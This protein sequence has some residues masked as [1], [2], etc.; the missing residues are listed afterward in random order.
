[1]A[2]TLYLR[3]KIRPMIVWA[4]I[5]PK[6]SYKEKMREEGRLAIY[7]FVCCGSHAQ[8]KKRSSFFA[9]KARNLIP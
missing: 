4:Q 9:C 8:S 2:M 3:K 6:D 1:M 7:N 5:D